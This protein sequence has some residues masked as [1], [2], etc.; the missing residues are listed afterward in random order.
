MKT[1]EIDIFLGAN[2]SRNL[3]FY[4]DQ[5]ELEDLS[6]VDSA[7]FVMKD[8][9]VGE[10]TVFLSSE[11]D[12]ESID[13]SILTLTVAPEDIAEIPPG[14]YVATVKVVMG[15]ETFVTDLIL[16]HVKATAEDA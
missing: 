16:V 9:V 1:N 15:E 7:T 12:L 5:D 13:D 10:G 4:N 14:D 2:A 6:D 8:T 3:V 11:L